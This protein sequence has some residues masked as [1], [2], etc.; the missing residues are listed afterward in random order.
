ME[1]SASSLFSFTPIQHAQKNNRKQKI[2]NTGPFHIRRR[3]DFC[4]EPV[5]YGT[6]GK[7]GLQ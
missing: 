4:Q 7:T 1:L 5:P 6:H 2:G 3:R